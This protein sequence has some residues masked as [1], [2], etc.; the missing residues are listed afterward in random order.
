MSKKVNLVVKSV[1]EDN[2]EIILD[3]AVP[4]RVYWV[5]PGI[6]GNGELLRAIQT[7]DPSNTKLGWEEDTRASGDIKLEDL[8]GIVKDTSKKILIVASRG[9]NALPDIMGA[10]YKG[11]ILWI[12]AGRAPSISQIFSSQNIPHTNTLYLLF[13]ENYDY[14]SNKPTDVKDIPEKLTDEYIMYSIREYIIPHMSP[15]SRIHYKLLKGEGHRPSLLQNEWER[16][17]HGG[18]NESNM[19]GFN[20]FLR[21]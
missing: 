10:G 5:G 21:D 4:T 8:K 13:S 15:E 20:V 3:L 9:C 17:I 1:R 16:L 11:P 14:G 18:L 6:G 2:G 7:I 12:N 19:D